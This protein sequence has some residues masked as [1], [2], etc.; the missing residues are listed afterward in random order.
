MEKICRC[1]PEGLSRDEILRKMRHL[2][3]GITTAELRGGKCENRKK[4]F[5]LLSTYN[6][7]C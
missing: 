6:C 7:N 3:N 1:N 2:H 5:E 4:R